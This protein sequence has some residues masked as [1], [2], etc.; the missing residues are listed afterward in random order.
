VIVRELSSGVVIVGGAAM[1]RVL[2]PAERERWRQ[3]FAELYAERQEHEPENE[4]QRLQTRV[5][6]LRAKY[7]DVFE[8]LS[9]DEPGYAEQARKETK[10]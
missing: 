1:A 3:M 10:S 2:S 6:K 9:T 8:T 5:E 4:Q 7:P